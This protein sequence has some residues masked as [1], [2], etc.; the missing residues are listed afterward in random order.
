MTGANR[1]RLHKTV[2]DVISDLWM[3]LQFSTDISSQYTGE[4]ATTTVVLRPEVQVTG[5]GGL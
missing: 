2:R 1:F 5:D 4:Y 3:Y